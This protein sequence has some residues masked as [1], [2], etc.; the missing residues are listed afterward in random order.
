MNQKTEIINNHLSNLV[1]KGELENEDIIS[2]VENMGSYLNLKTISDYA[3]SEKISYNA[4]LKRI[5]TKNIQVLRIFNVR[6]VID[7]L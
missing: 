5:A 6:F 7:N 3:T 4:V 2:I 1:Q